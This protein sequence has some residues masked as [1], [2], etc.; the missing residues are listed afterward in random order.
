MKKGKRQHGDA[1]GTREREER[2]TG[3]V[4]VLNKKGER[5]DPG[6]TTGSHGGKVEED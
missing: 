1:V 6:S 5:V 3:S 4:G 2:I